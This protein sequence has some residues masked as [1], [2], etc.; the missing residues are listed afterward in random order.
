VRNERVVIELSTKRGTVYVVMVAAA[1]VGNLRLTEPSR[2]FR[3]RES[4]TAQGDTSVRLG[5]PLKVAAGAELGA[6]LLGSTVV[7]VF[8]KGVVGELNVS[9]GDTVLQ[10]APMARSEGGARV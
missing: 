9:V 3:G 10:G 1:G 7:V 2:E 4:S 6:F 8:E 5:Q